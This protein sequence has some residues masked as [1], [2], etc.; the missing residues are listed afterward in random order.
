MKRSFVKIIALVILSAALLSLAS[1]KNK[2]A[3]DNEDMN[4]N[5]VF[6]TYESASNVVYCSAEYKLN[7]PDTEVETVD[8]SCRAA[9]GKLII[10]NDKKGIAYYGTYE[11]AE[12]DDASY[13]IKMSTEDGTSRGIAQVS[14]VVLHDDSVEYNLIIV[15]DGYTMHFKSLDK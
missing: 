8:L 10:M 14:K 4:W 2:L 5:I 9:N 12:S 3:I 6:I 1:C 13:S 7:Y 15:I 11:Q